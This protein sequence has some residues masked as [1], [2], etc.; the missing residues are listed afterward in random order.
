MPKSIQEQIMCLGVF[1]EART[2]WIL[3][4]NP[5]YVNL[6]AEFLI[7][8]N[9]LKELSCEVRE[10]KPRMILKPLKSLE[11]LCAVYESVANQHIDEMF[12]D[13]CRLTNMLHTLF[14]SMLR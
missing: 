6:R 9:L 2:Q 11:A 1:F 8:V 5:D 10:K 4:S 12:A 7:E 14:L 3:E 13:A